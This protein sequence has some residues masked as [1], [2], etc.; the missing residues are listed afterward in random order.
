MS[1]TPPPATTPWNDRIAGE[2]ADWYSRFV[3]YRD[4]GP[5]RTKL[6]A[7]HLAEAKAVEEGRKKQSKRV[8]GAW[9]AAIARWKWEERATAYDAEQQRRL[10]QKLAEDRDNALNTG[11]G[12]MHERVKAIK[13]MEALVRG[14]IIA[15]SLAA[16][17]LQE[18]LEGEEGDDDAERER[19]RGTSNEKRRKRRKMLGISAT[20]LEQWRGLLDDIAKEKGERIK[21]TELSGNADKP[22]IVMP[23]EGV[24]PI[25]VRDLTD[26]QLDALLA[27]LEQSETVRTARAD[28]TA[29]DEDT[30]PEGGDA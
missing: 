16:T 24:I 15:S 6:G 22:L 11:L 14:E 5:Q 3:L 4:M 7:V 29:S 18:S 20:L 26:E 1:E 9:N 8:P 12:Q 10:E 21:K 28:D 2:P 17:L 23:Q 30:Q 19:E 13:E 25:N 27:I